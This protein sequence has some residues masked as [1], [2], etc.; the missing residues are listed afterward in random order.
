MK[1]VRVTL[2]NKPGALARVVGIISA[3]GSNIESLAVAPDARH[4]GLSRITLS[5]ELDGDGLRWALGKIRNLVHV[6]RVEADF[7]QPDR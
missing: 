1:Q 5:S 3:T 6:I 2:E 7:D 4:L